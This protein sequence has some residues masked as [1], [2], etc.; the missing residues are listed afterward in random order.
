MASL[1]GIVFYVFWLFIVYFIGEKVYLVTM[2]YF[3]AQKKIALFK[4]QS[5]DVYCKVKDFKLND[6]LEENIPK[7]GVKQL[8]DLLT[9]KKATCV[10]LVKFYTRTAIQRCATLNYVTEYFYDEAVE[11][12]QKRDKQLKELIS[13]GG[14]LPVLFGIPMS[15][16]DVIEVKGRDT[17]L[18]STNFCFKP[19]IQNGLVVDMLLE[20]GAIPFVKTNAPQLLLINETNNWVWGRAINP[21]DKDRSTGG[22]SGGEGGIVAMGCSPLGLGSDG[23]GSV[24][25]PANYCGLYGVRPTGKR[26][27]LLGHKPPSSYTPRHIFGCMGPLAKSMDDCQRLLEAVQNYEILNIYDP[28]L[29]TLKWN[30][31]LVDEYVTSKKLRIGIIPALNVKLL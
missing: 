14:Q 5:H 1:Y 31:Q 27:T 8:Q 25:I 9:S 28:F 15:L 21:W 29:P 26:F 19:E 11:L 3:I 24:R 7:M 18:G 10:D 30:N 13:K 22:S 17:S 16:K 20:A 4:Q 6:D 23:G 12:A 2:H